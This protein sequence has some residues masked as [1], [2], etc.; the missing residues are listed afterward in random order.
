[1]KKLMVMLL[2]LMIS[3]LFVS[4]EKDDTI[5]VPSSQQILFECFYSNYAWGC[6]HQGF[7]IDRKGEIMTYSQYPDQTYLSDIGW[8]FPD[9]EG[10]ISEQALMENLQKTTVRDTLIDMN[11][12]KTYSD[13]IYLV[14]NNDFTEYQQMYDAGSMVYTCYQYNENTKTYK[15]IKLSENGDFVRINN[16]KYAKQI[17]D[18][19]KTI[20]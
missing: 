13:K 2:T 6:V 11:T 5:P 17:S 1:M 4:C 12:L 16:N 8:N 7:F 18:W 3:G 9:N 10:N 20:Q 15:Q 14:T 19:L